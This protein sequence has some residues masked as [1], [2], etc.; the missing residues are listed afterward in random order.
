MDKVTL[1]LLLSLASV[2]CLWFKFRL[3][4]NKTVVNNLKKEEE[5]RLARLARVK[6]ITNR[7]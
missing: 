4:E 3:D 2:F 6:Q 1:G 7:H 5:E